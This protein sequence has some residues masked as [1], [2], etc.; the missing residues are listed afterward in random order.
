MEKRGFGE[1][2]TSLSTS[3]SYQFAA[4]ISLGFRVCLLDEDVC[5]KKTNSGNFVINPNRT[6]FGALLLN[7]Y[8]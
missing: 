2:Y 4:E 7:W 8:A 3:P 6:S 5:F 1:I